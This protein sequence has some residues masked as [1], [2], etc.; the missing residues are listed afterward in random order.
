MV[1][2]TRTGRVVLEVLVELSPGVELDHAGSELARLVRMA[3][4][5]L[6][7]VNVTQAVVLGRTQQDDPGRST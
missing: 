1:A 5:V 7:G 2:D 6:D 4:G 3:G